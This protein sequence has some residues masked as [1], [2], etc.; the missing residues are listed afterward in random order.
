MNER[1]RIKALLDAGKI[2]Q[3]EANLLLSALEEGDEA[4][5]QADQALTDT[6]GEPKLQAETPNWFPHNIRWVKVRLT[7]GELEATLDPSLSQPAIDSQAEVRQSGQ[8]LEVIPQSPAGSFL[9][10]I[11]GG[12]GVGQVKVRLPAGWGL[13]VDSK[14]AQ[15]EAEGIQFLKGRVMA[16]NVELEG[17]G[18]LDLEVSAGNIEGSLLLKEGQHRLR[19]SMGNADLDLLSGSSVKLNA[20]VSMG[21][22]ET[23]GFAGYAQTPDASTRPLGHVLGDGKANLDLSVRM[24]NLEVK[25]K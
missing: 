14:A 4:A 18:G 24:G 25:A 12:I 8:D 9:S 3:D 17:V 1:E 2:T 5:R 20:S 21:N 16:G 13:D 11:F 23:K 10:G 6:V 7:A 22:L 15:I 19:V